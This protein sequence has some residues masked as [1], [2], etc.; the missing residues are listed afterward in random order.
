MMIL[1]PDFH[2]AGRATVALRDSNAVDAVEVFDRASL[3]EGEKDANMCELLPGLAGCGAECAALL[4]ECRGA[5]EEKL[6]ARIATATGALLESKTVS[7]ETVEKYPFRHDEK[8]YC[9]FWDFRKGLIPMVG[10]SRVAGTS[11][12]IEDVACPVENLADMSCDLI[13]MF[14]RNNYKASV[15][16]H[17]MEGNMHLVFAQ[18]FND[19]E[20]LDQFSDM[21]DDMCNIVAVKYG[22][23]LKGEHGTGR[24]VAPY[25]E[26][27]WGKR[28]TDI[29]WRVKQLFDPEGMLNP[30]VILNVDPLVH[31]KNLKPSPLASK[32]VDRCIEC[33]FCESNCPSKDLSLTPRQRITTWREVNRLQRL[34]D[35]GLSQPSDRT[36]L[37][38]M[39]EGY[40]YDGIDTCAA[41]G[42]CQEK[43][44]VRVAARAAAAAAALSR[45]PPPLSSVGENQ[46]GRPDQV[47]PR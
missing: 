8:V 1:F 47:D 46:H 30:G 21:M 37:V 28:A 3:A 29:M 6:H 23:S 22:G 40:E 11:M 26:L 32:L 9:A 43:C 31:L 17:A 34:V 42:M 45:S 2:S 36:R 10:A 7:E 5:D 14:K 38:E 24:N 13:A 4:I 20:D 15:F 35:S 18:G 44:P 25:V 19:G 41:D 33:G 12:L 27:E 16:G 39:R